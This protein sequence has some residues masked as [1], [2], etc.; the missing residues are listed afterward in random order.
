MAVVLQIGDTTA[1]TAGAM[2]RFHTR[3]AVN[4]KCIL[5]PT[6]WWTELGYQ[7]RWTD[8]SSGKVA[9]RYGLM[10]TI[11]TTKLKRGG[12]VVDFPVVLCNDYR[13]WKTLLVATFG[14]VL[15]N[16]VISRCGAFCVQL[17]AAHILC[18]KSCTHSISDLADFIGV[19]GHRLAQDTV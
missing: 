16:L 17:H 2:L 6:A 12:T 3:S 15:A 1:L 18:R 4:V 11:L 10:G 14:P 19:H 13:D 7:H 9:I 8:L 5:S